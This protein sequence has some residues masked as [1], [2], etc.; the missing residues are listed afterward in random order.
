MEKLQTFAICK[1]PSLYEKAQREKGEVSN[2]SVQN[3]DAN[4]EHSFDY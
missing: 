1:V 3:L 4:V 2:K